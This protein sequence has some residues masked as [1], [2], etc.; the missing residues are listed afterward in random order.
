MEEID[1]D[2]FDGTVGSTGFGKMTVDQIPAWNVTIAAFEVISRRPNGT[3]TCEASAAFTMRAVIAA[4]TR[5]EALAQ[6]HR[7]AEAAHGDGFVYTVAG[8]E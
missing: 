7:R 5:E 3:G 1:V 2:V 6:A 8:G 4:R